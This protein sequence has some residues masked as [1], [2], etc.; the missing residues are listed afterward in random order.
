MYQGRLFA[1]RL[2]AGQLFQQVRQ[3]AEELIGGGG[4][5]VLQLFNK[6]PWEHKEEIQLIYQELVA[7]EVAG[8]AKV[9][10]PYKD[11][12]RIDWNSLL[13]DIETV[14]KILRL[15]IQ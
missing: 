8:V 6:R 7:K 15:K 4:G 11:I 13:H 1:G 3:S 14:K 2:F 9:V 5:W 10:A 12:G